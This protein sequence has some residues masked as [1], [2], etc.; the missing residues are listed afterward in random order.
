MTDKSQIVQGLSLAQWEAMYRP[1]MPEFTA[2]TF[3]FSLEAPELVRIAFGNLGPCI[4]SQGERSPVYTH[5]VTL[6]PGV[7]VE[8]ARALLNHYANP[9]DDLKR[10]IAPL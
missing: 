1:G 8:L 2:A 4:N 7:A 10:P 5:A 9:A 3:A 6:P